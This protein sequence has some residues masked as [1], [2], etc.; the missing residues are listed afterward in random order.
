MAVESMNYKPLNGVPL[1]LVKATN[2]AKLSDPSLALRISNLPPDIAET[3][4]Q[5]TFTAFGEVVSIDV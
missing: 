2:L 1:R 3:D 5:D 4:L